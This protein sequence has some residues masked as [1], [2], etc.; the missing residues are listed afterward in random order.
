[1]N[2]LGA[3]IFD[4]DGVI[5]DTAKYHFL[6][7]KKL[8]DQLNIPFTEQDN[9]RLKG[10]SRADSLEILL[11]LG[12]VRYEEEDKKRFMEQKNAVY[13]EYISH[14][15]E[16]EILPGVLE[17]LEY[18]REHGIKISLGS[19]S[20]NAVM[21]LEN[22]RLESYFDA[23]ID[24]NRVKRAKPDPE[25]FLKGAL[26]VSVSPKECVVFEDAQ[27]G[28]AGAK[29][30]GMKAVGIGKPDVLTGADFVISGFDACAPGDLLQRIR[31]L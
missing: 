25:V 23:V 30:A 2:L 14:M 20:K 6:A 19:V 4:M 3:C 17:F 11:G 8:A 27:A 5:C 29:A 22:L 31:S 15:D 9:E 26:E 13:V 10:V 24:G 21:I 16:K 7:W 28:I 12:N 18:L 1:M